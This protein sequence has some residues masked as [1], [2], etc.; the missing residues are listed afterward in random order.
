[1]QI[2]DVAYMHL[3]YDHLAVLRAEDAWSQHRLQRL[4]DFANRHVGKR[5]NAAG[6]SQIEELKVQNIGT[7]MQQLEEYFATRRKMVSAN[8]ELYF[9]SE[10]VGAAFIDAGIISDSAALFFR[11]ETLTPGDLIKDKAFGFFVG[12]VPKFKEYE[13]PDDDWFTTNV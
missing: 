10:L 3:A 11:P 1:V 9:C 5:F 6:I 8:R 12:F 13:I 7:A 2:T 4:R